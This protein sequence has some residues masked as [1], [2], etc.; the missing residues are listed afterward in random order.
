[1]Y[2]MKNF[3]RTF[4]HLGPTISRFPAV[5]DTFWKAGIFKVGLRLANHYANYAE[6]RWKRE[7][8]F[9][10]PSHLVADVTNICALRCPLCP[11]GKGEPGRKKGMMSLT[12]YKKIIDEMG[13]HL[14]SLDLFNW[15]E[16]LLN[17]DIYEMIA[18]AHR[19]NIVTSVSTNFQSFSENDAERLISSGLDILILSIDGASQESYE[20]Y[21][22]GGDFRK[23]IEHISILVKKKKEKGSARPYICWQ[24]LVM[25]HNEHEVEAAKK[26]AQDLGIDSITI[27]HA[28]LLVTTR[29]EGEKWLPSDP[30]NHRYDLKQLE[31][32]WKAIE[33]AHTVQPVAEKQQEAVAEMHDRPGEYVNVQNNFHRRADC[34]WL[35]TQTTINWDGS[36]SPCCA[37]YAPSFDFD[38]ISE[39]SFKK[40]WNNEKYRAS[41]RFSSTGEAGGT[42]TVCMQCPL[43]L[44]G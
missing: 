11:T 25:R 42:I 13:R 32:R 4:P 28:Y 20:K 39:T 6:M 21:R 14:I 1:M 29:E 23:A 3:L 5:S 43:A 26:M 34:S 41:R 17:K 10:R 19:Q 9:S 27:D 12:T 37:V 7:T 24:F 30:K 40:V 2:K 18:Y 22:V 16:P 8:L 15:G 44:H 38:N 33:E 35:W 36:V 31:T